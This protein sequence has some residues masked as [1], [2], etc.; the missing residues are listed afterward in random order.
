MSKS[1]DS[2]FWDSGKGIRIFIYDHVRKIN[3]RD[4]IIRNRDVILK[5]PGRN[6]RL[7]SNLPV[8]GNGFAFMRRGPTNTKKG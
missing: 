4:V 3:F 6:S 1:C 5:I 2:N 8:T 7:C